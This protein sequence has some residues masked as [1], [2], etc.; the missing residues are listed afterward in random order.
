[1][2]HVKAKR[3]HIKKLQQRNKRISHHEKDSLLTYI[4]KRNVLGSDKFTE[5]PITFIIQKVALCQIHFSCMVG[6]SFLTETK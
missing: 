4:G 6:F 2:T 3:D 5:S 1:M